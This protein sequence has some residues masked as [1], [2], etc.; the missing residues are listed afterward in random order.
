[1]DT[2]RSLLQEI[3]ELSHTVN[4]QGERIADLEGTVVNEMARTEAA[5]DEVRRVRAR[6]TRIVEEVRDRASGILADTSMLI[7]EVMDTVQS[8]VPEGTEE[9][10]EEDPEEEV[11][12]DSPT[13]D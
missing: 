1:M 12:P 9:D 13:V 10:P 11:P 4:A 6:L 5:R 8:L 2:N 7:D 3:E